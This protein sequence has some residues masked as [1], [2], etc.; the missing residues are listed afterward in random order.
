MA[1]NTNHLMEIDDDT[2]FSSGRIMMIPFERHFEEGKRDHTLKNTLKSP[3][4]A[5]GIFNWLL[6][7]Y[8]SFKTKGLTPP[9]KSVEAL[10]AYRK[11]CDSIALYFENILIKSKDEWVKTSILFSDYKNWYT[12]CDIEGKSQKEFVDTLRQ[13]GLLSRH[14]TDGHIVRGYK[15]KPTKEKKETQKKEAIHYIHA[16]S[17]TQ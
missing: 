4:N 16:Q 15:M 7:G 3:E 8:S 9:K 11:E 13:K 14:N 2:V 1:I 6:Q 10:E 5:S 17:A 12:R